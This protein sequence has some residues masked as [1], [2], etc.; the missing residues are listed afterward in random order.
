VIG[1]DGRLRSAAAGAGHT[2]LANAALVVTV[3]ASTPQPVDHLLA[4]DGDLA[5]DG[6]LVPRRCL[7]ELM[8]QAVGL[9]L[10]LGIGERRVVRLGNHCIGH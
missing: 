3:I 7:L 6:R 5:Q 10:E 9:V 2:R 8:H 4:E 1:E